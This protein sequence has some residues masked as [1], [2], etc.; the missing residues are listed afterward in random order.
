M[1]ILQYNPQMLEIETESILDVQQRVG[2]KA[3]KGDVLVRKRRI[4]FA[5]EM[6]GQITINLPSRV[7]VYNASPDEINE[8][9]DELRDIYGEELAETGAVWGPPMAGRAEPVLT[10]YSDA[11]DAEREEIRDIVGFDVTFL[12]LTAPRP[13]TA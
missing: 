1:L 12:T 13:Q 3:E 9:V 2:Y 11:T 5:P 7:G 8:Q 10:L 6:I 4:F